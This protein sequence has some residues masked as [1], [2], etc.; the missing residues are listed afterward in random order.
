MQAPILVKI[1]EL[2]ANL[3]QFRR[4]SVILIK[5]LLFNSLIVHSSQIVTQMNL[6]SL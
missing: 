4:F 1:V 5:N 3:L 2:I 6:L